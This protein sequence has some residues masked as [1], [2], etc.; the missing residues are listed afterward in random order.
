VIT[1]YLLRGGSG[2][3][4]SRGRAY[5]RRRD[6]AAVLAQPRCPP[7]GPRIVALLAKVRPAPPALPIEQESRGVW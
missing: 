1:E 7:P 3:Q 6:A 4:K 5:R 2:K